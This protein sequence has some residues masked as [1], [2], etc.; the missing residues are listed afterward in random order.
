MI[1]FSLYSMT[2]RLIRSGNS[3]I[4][5]IFCSCVRFSLASE[6]FLYVIPFVLSTTSTPAFLTHDVIL[7]ICGGCFFRSINSYLI[8]LESK[9]FIAFLTLPQFMIPYNFMQ[10]PVIDF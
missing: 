10:T 4:F 7:S 9:K 1:R 2:G 8:C 3:D 6:S 5:W